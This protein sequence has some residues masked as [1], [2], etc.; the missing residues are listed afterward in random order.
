MRTNCYFWHSTN[1]LKCSIQ[2]FKTSLATRVFLSLLKYVHSSPEMVILLCVN[3][4]VRC[5]FSAKWFDS[6]T[7]I[8]IKVCIEWVLIQWHTNRQGFHVNWTHLQSCNFNI[9][10]NKMVSKFNLQTWKQNI[11][12]IACVARV[13]PI[14]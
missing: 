1:G 6:R 2:N 7:F 12:S 5:A 11:D 14:S 9:I 13:A 10:L 8:Q 3:I 4:A